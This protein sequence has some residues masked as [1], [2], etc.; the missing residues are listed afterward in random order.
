MSYSNEEAQRIR[1][2]IDSIPVV[3]MTQSEYIIWRVETREEII[4]EHPNWNKYQQDVML[5][6]LETIYNIKRVGR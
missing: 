5:G 4:I 6:A 2:D 1:R 3:E